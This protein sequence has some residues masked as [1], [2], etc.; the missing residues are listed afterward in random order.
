M[1]KSYGEEEKIRMESWDCLKNEIS[2][3]TEEMQA[4]KDLI[5]QAIGEENAGNFQSCIQVNN[6]YCDGKG[7]KGSKGRRLVMVSPRGG[8]L[9]NQSP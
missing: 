9:G 7:T 5:L 4:L 6:L 8:G 1:Q 2:A 3:N